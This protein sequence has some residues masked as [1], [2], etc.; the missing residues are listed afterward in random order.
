MFDAIRGVVKDG[1]IIP[2]AQLP[3]G[4][5]V[6]IRLSALHVVPVEMTSAVQSEF[7]TWQQTN[8]ELLGAVTLSEEQ[9]A[10]PASAEAAP[11]SESDQTEPPR[12]SEETK[13]GRKKPK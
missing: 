11:A 3:E 10:P 9:A 13:S 12:K 1:V 2:E 5:Q 8:A 4:A 6:E 7:E